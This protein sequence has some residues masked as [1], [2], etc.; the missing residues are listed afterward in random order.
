MYNNDHHRKVLDIDQQYDAMRFT[1][2]GEITER[3]FLELD[4]VV[5]WKGKDREPPGT[6]SGFR[7]KRGNGTA[8]LRWGASQ[9][10]LM[11]AYYEVLRKE[12]D[13][14]K[15]I[16]IATVPYLD[17]PDDKLDEGTYVIRAVDVAGNT[18]GCSA[19]VDFR[20]P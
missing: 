3:S 1:L 5:V 13:E 6:P 17:V 7:I 18:S 20:R 14:L 11:I 12:G 19:T 16:T 8:E 4:W 15:R 9:D 2:N 10:N